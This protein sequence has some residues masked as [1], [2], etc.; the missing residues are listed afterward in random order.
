MLFSPLGSP[1]V[2]PASP[3]HYVPH[4]V[5]GNSL[6]K[7]AAAVIQASSIRPS[8]AI[9]RTAVTRAG[10]GRPI[11]SGPYTGA[12]SQQVQ[13]QVLD[14]G[15]TPTISAPLHRG[16]GTDS[17]ADLAVLSGAT[18]QSYTL[19]CI[20][21]GVDSQTAEAEIEGY[22][23]RANNPGEDGNLINLVVDSSGLTFTLTDYALLADLPSG[24]AYQ[25]GPEWSLG[26]PAGIGERVPP[27]ALRLCFGDDRSVIYTVW[28]T[29]VDGDWRTQFVPAIQRTYKRGETVYSVTGTRAVSVSDGVTTRDYTNILC[30]RDLLVAI[31]ADASALVEVLEL[32]SADRLRSN[33]AAFADLRLQTDARV[34]WTAGTGSDFARGFVNAWVDQATAQT[35]IIQARCFASTVAEGAALGREKWLVSGS[36]SGEL[37]S[38]TTGDAWQHPEGG[39][40]SMTTLHHIEDVLDMVLHLSA[41]GVVFA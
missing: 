31:D 10:N 12:Q 38:A 2:E 30:V 14:G 25:I 8:S 23:I 6:N 22:R 24:I 19:T 28:R 9:R 39:R 32:P 7:L 17:I 41:K 21:L 36:L 37:G 18:S 29:Y 20:D 15:T 35:E 34:D 4:R 33:P 13:V 16:V 1:G 40:H 27:D 11:L 3:R 26:A 5:I